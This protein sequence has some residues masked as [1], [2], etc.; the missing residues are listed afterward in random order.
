MKVEI[1]IVP[2]GKTLIVLETEPTSTIADLKKQ[3]AKNKRN[4]YVERQSLRLQLKSK[5]IADTVTLEALDLKTDCK[6]YFKD[7]GPQLG[8][9]TVFFWE[10]FGPLIMYLISYIRPPILY[11]DISTTKVQPIVHVAA[12]CWAVHYIKRIL[13]TFFVHRFSKGTMPLRNLFKNCTYYWTFAFFIGY[14]INHPLY[15]PAS[16]GLA[17]IYIGLIGFVLSEVGNLNIHILLRNLRPPG[18]KERKIPQPTSNPFT[19]MFHFVSC[20]NYTYEVM[21]WFWFSIMTQCLTAFLFTIAGFYQMAVW[22][23]LKH[24]SYKKD[25]PSYPKQR[26]AIVPF[27]L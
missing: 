24:R 15:T 10:Y 3:I 6:L 11:G 21:A 25:F 16:F 26:K 4:L 17:Q 2:S 14:S 5:T 19:L 8:W 20:P 22:A 27:F 18:T 13:E 23:L 1:L 12:I 7:L 9:T